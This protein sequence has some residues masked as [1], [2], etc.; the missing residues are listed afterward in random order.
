MATL[1]F[2]VVLLTPKR[3]PILYGELV[4]TTTIFSLSMGIMVLFQSDKG[5]LLTFKLRWWPNNYLEPRLGAHEFLASKSR[6]I[7]HVRIP[8]T[9]HH[10]PKTS[11]FMG[12]M[13]IFLPSLPSTLEISTHHFSG[14]HH[15]STKDDQVKSLSAAFPMVSKDLPYTK[16]IVLLHLKAVAPLTSRESCRL[17]SKGTISCLSGAVW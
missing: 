7:Q 12:D 4:S 14:W 17:G 10:V 6:W 5:D 15:Q 3:C 16:I 13:S 8:D 2:V 9:P 11:L 1:V